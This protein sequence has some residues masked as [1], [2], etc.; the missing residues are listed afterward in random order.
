MAVNVNVN[1]NDNR[2]GGG[3]MQLIAYGAPDVYLIGNGGVPFNTRDSM[4][5]RWFVAREDGMAT[6]DDIVGTLTTTPSTADYAAW[7]T[8]SILAHAPASMAPPRG[9]LEPFSVSDERANDPPVTAFEEY[10]PIFAD[11]ETRSVEVK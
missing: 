3:L 8:G 6:R 1:V 11:L 4:A 7:Q 10:T 5:S 2:G 9:S